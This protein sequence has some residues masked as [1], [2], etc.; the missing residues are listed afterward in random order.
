MFQ[1]TATALLAMCRK[2]RKLGVLLALL[3]V[4]VPFLHPLAEA[5]AAGRPDAGV[6]CSSFGAADG[7]INPA[8]PDDC[9]MGIAGC[10]VVATVVKS[11]AAAPEAISYPEVCAFTLRQDHRQDGGELAL[12]RRPPGRAPPAVS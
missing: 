6:I 10:G 11:E 1:M 2:E 4:L 8:M 7:K 3:L 12:W 5:N 9:P